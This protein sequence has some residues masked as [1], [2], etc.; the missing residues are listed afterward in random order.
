MTVRLAE[1]LGIDT[2]LSTAHRFGL[3]ENAPH[4]LS[5]VLGSQEVTPLQ[6]TNA[7][8]MIAN[9]GLKVAP[10]LIERI[11]DGQ[12]KTLFRF[13]RRPCKDC[14]VSDIEKLGSND[15]PMLNEPRERVLDP[16]VAY[17]MTSILQG[18]VQRGTAVAAKKLGVPVAGKTGTTNESRDTWFVGFSSDLVVGVF[19]GYDQP[20][21]LGRRETGGRVALPAFISFME[22]A[23]KKYPAKEF[24]V[25]EGI[26]FEAINAHTGDQAL[27]WLQAGGSPS[28]PTIQEAFITGGSIYIPGETAEPT[29]EAHY[30]TSGTETPLTPETIK[31]APP[32]NV[33]DQA[34][35]Y[36]SQV[37]A[38]PNAPTSNSA[39]NMMPVPP[40]QMPAQ[41]KRDIGEAPPVGES[42]PAGTGTGGLY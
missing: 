33:S 9:G 24:P 20:K 15:I 7:Y 37:T 28:G 13:D 10:S 19:V 42:T 12:G 21:T 18:V 23:L 41:Q 11:D 31:T 30:Q 14:V 29:E 39:V 8:A 5:I 40:A 2:I 36:P 38:E 17:Q 25:P 32:R 27:P 1:A 22:K 3:Y 26:Q 4:M 35:T 16:R 34:F 6:I